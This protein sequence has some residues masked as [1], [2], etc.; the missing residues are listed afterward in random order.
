[1]FTRSLG[2]LAIAVAILAPGAALAQLGSELDSPTGEPRQPPPPPGAPTPPV[3]PPVA[4]PVGPPVV[5]APPATPPGSNVGEEEEAVVPLPETG[6]EEP[7]AEAPAGDRMRMIVIDAATFG[8][9]PVVGRV[10][11]A[12]MR[13]TGEELGYAVLTP[14]ESVAPAPGRTR[15]ST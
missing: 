7:P 1:M 15:A 13:T 12:R 8:I 5:E 3:P 11:S 10:V 9:D 2:V 4:P 14:E 6:T